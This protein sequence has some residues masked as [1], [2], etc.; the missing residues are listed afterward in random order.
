MK[1]KGWKMK[2]RWYKRKSKDCTRNDNECNM[3]PRGWN[4]EAQNMVNAT[5][6]YARVESKSFQ[7]LLRLQV[8]MFSKS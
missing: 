5:L 6:C 2:T 4:Y 8:S 3:R 1:F 7:E